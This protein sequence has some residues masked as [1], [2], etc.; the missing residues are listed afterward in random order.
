RRRAMTIRRASAGDVDAVIALWA[1][2]RTTAAST[3]D[4]A[5]G[6]EG[7]IARGALLVAEVDGALVGT[8][9]AGWDG[10]RGNMYRLAVLP[11]H[12]RCAAPAARR[13]RRAPRAS[14][15]GRRSPARSAPAPRRPAAPGS[16]PGRSRTAASS[17]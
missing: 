6:V 16:G 13:A 11:S 10:W 4:D 17:R 14:A 2:A 12:R 7:A 9:I 3:P 8:L 5:A 1:A 15:R